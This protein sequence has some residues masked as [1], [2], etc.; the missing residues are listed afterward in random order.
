MKWVSDVDE[1][2]HAASA[3]G[4]GEGCLGG[5]GKVRARWEGPKLSGLASKHSQET[6]LFP[7]LDEDLWVSRH[8]KEAQAATPSMLCTQPGRHGCLF[9]AVS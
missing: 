2:G 3:L 8:G 6:L 5:E 1:V 7:T 9:L 4:V